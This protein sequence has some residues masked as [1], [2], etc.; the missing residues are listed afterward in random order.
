MHTPE[1]HF[2]NTPLHDFLLEFSTSASIIGCL[3]IIVTYFMYKDIRTPSR[4]I[5]LCISIADFVAAVVNFLVK[6]ADMPD[7]EIELNLCIIQSY[8]SSIA[9]LCSFFWTVALSVFLNILIVQKDA[10]FA[11]WLMYRF[12]HPICWLIPVI[13]NLFALF[14]H[15]LGNS[16]DFVASGWCWIQL[17][18]NGIYLVIVY[19]FFSKQTT[20]HISVDYSIQ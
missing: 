18:L 16:Y 17:E 4:H 12:F 1:Q 6:F 5:I 15:K 14:Y 7:N 3:I 2:S 8:V 11:D 9:T 13:I 10:L 19:F 20:K